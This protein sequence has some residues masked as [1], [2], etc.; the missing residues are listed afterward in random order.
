MYK[1][2]D[3]SIFEK[4]ALSDKEI[5]EAIRDGLLSRNIFSVSKYKKFKKD[6]NNLNR[7]Y[8]YDFKFVNEL[9]IRLSYVYTSKYGGVST[10]YDEFYI[11]DF[12][13]IC[14]NDDAFYVIPLNKVNRIVLKKG[15]NHSGYS[16]A[17]TKEVQKSPVKGAIAGALIAG[18]TGAVIGS[19][20]GTGTKT[21]TI[22]SASSWNYNDFNL[23]IIMEGNEEYFFKCFNQLNA[24]GTYDNKN[25]TAKLLI[26]KASKIKTNTV[27]KE[28]VSSTIT[29]GKKAATKEKALEV[30]AY[31][32]M[33][34][35][36]IGLVMLFQSC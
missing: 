19:A 26:E 16:P 5:D 8:N 18:T 12:Y 13:F 28:I 31:I 15:D 22:V 23:Q 25:E 4:Y 2:K 7:E 9:G 3:F 20:M 29:G 11:T 35:M 10:S 1:Y 27:K 34:I 21:K 36:C 33:G 6:Y 30:V 14:V 32:I 24:G 17:I